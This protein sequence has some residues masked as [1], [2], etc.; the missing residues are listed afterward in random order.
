MGGSDE[1]KIRAG[2]IVAARRVFAA[3]GLHAARITDIT[4][5]ARVAAGSFYTYFASKDA[6]FAAVVDEIRQQGDRHVTLG[7]SPTTPTEAVEWLAQTVRSHTQGLIESVG[8]WLHINIAT[9]GDEELCATIRDQHDPFS[10]ALRVAFADWCSRGW[11]DAGVPTDLAV[12]A[13][14]AMSEQSVA[15]WFL[16]DPVR[17]SEDFAADQLVL[18]WTEALRFNLDSVGSV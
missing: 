17:P 7:P 5:E 9:L 3:K 16:L 6:I 4:A 8:E 10:E 1:P 12:E 13:L 11:I 2:L 15:Q 14:T 18:G